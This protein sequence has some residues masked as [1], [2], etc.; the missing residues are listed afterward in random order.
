MAEIRDFNRNQYLLKGGKNKKGNDIKKENKNHKEK[1]TGQNNNRDQKSMDSM[2][3]RHRQLKLYTVLAVAAVAA[4]VAIGAYI[5]WKN[6]VYV[7][8]SVVQ[9]NE[10]LRASESKTINLKGT[11]FTYSNDGMSCTDLK[12]KTIWNQTYEMQNPVIRTCNKTVAVGDY[13]GRKI[14]VANAQGMLGTIETTLPI[15]D[16]C[17]SSNGV[18]AAVLDDSSVTAIYLYSAT[19]K[20]FADFKTRMSNSGYP[21]A[22]DISN[23]GSLVAVSYIKAEKGKVVSNIGFYNFSSVGQNYTDNFVSGYG[24]PE[25]VIPLVHFMGNDTI[26]AV[27]DNRIMFFKGKQTPESLSEDMISEEIQSVFY[28]ESHVG[29]VFYNTAA[30]TKYRIEIYDTSAKKVREL[31]FDVEYKDIM[32]DSTGIVIYNDSECIL[33]DWDGRLKY[34]GAFSDKIICFVPGGSI[35]RHTLVTEASIQSIELQ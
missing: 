8:Y 12:G 24:Y 29:L 23:D 19:G 18:V 31:M 15:R 6:K 2:L 21:I 1:N 10:W 32:F 17:V 7:S 5:Q 16:F 11:L 25:A 26:F 13:N 30:D 20:S 34:Q 28:N 4:V 3:A 35:S 9:E 33:Y 22:V 27:A 14:Y